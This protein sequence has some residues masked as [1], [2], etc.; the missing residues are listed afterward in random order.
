MPTKDSAGRRVVDVEL[1]TDP[2]DSGEPVEAGDQPGEPGQAEQ[3]AGKPSQA[4]D[5]SSHWVFMVDPSWKPVEKDAEPPIAAVVGGWYVDD[6]GVTGLFHANPRY[7]PSEPN[8][9]TDPVDA[10][11]HLTVSGK[12]DSDELLKTLP[13]IVYGVG[14]DADGT[15]VVAPAPD[16]RPSVLVTTAP[17]HR[18]RVRVASWLEVTMAELAEALPDEGV[19]VLLNPGAPNSVRLLAGAV[20]ESVASA[21]DRSVGTPGRAGFFARGDV[22]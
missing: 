3:A 14:L 9:P 16:G 10:A 13:Q 7:V 4:E 11:L 19:D 1:S 15:P 5:L 2:Q 20:K 22:S 21:A 17:A 12:V 8:L 18:A 6:D